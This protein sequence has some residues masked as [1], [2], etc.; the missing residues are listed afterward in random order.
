[1]E[2]VRSREIKLAVTYN[3][4]AA[5]QALMLL[6]QNQTP[7]ERAIGISLENN[8]IGFDAIDDDFLSECADILSCEGFDLNEKQTTR[9]KRILPKYTGQLMRI[10]AMGVYFP[11]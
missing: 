5:K 1:M 10:E 3:S 9:L 8:Y 7:T 2:S 11:I 6:W 4:D